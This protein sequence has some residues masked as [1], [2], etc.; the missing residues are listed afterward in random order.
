MQIAG[1]QPL[2]QISRLVANNAPVLFQAGMQETYIK[3]GQPRR[4]KLEP[5]QVV[6]VVAAKTTRVAE[7][8][9]SA[10]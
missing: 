8:M 1:L 2:L 5:G 7:S 9:R 3:V 4:P 6:E 10:M